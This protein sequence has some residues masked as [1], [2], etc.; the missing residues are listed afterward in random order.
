MYHHHE[1][2]KMH[3]RINTHQAWNGWASGTCQTLIPSGFN[4]FCRPWSY[5][6]S[7]YPDHCVLSRQF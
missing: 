1:E 4:H 3:P 7:S 2:E 5:V 6:F